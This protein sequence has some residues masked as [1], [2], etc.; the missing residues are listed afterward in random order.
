MDHDTGGLVRSPFA[1]GA[2]GALVT[3]IRFTPGAT[4]QERAFN[5]AAGACFSGFLTPAVTDWLGMSKPS[6]ASGAA[7]LLGLLGMSLASAVL[8][9]IKQTQV[10]QIITGWISRK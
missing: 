1:I 9:G 10:G 2:L 6:Y 4:W 8:D 5:T 7:F 3:A